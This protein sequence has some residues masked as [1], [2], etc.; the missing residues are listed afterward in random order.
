M[1]Q[2]ISCRASND[3]GVA[4]RNQKFLMHSAPHCSRAAVTVLGLNVCHETFPRLRLQATTLSCVPMPLLACSCAPPS[5]PT[6]CGHQQRHAFSH[7]NQ[8]PGQRRRRVTTGTIPH[9]SSHSKPT[10][11]VP[12][13]A[14]GFWRCRSFRLKCCATAREIAHCQASSGFKLALHCFRSVIEAADSTTPRTEDCP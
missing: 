7:R 1:R 5:A 11:A 2:L 8:S 13:H 4:G 12:L 9:T 6:H 3:N 10:D 14:P